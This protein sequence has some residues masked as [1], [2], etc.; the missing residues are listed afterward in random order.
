MDR[1][2]RKLYFHN[3]HNSNDGRCKHGTYVGGCGADYMC[4]WCEDGTPDVEYVEYCRQNRV[5]TLSQRNWKHIA[6]KL[7]AAMLEAG[8]NPI[9]DRYIIQ[10]YQ[11]CGKVGVNLDNFYNA[12][13]GR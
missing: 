9:G 3:W 13:N 1:E 6:P 2:T 10:M 5:C 8:S 4:G 7:T 12:A 11:S